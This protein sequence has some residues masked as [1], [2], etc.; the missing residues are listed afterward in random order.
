MTFVKPAA[1]TAAP[2]QEA[3]GRMEVF[4][5][6]TALFQTHIDRHVKG[7][8]LFRKAAGKAPPCLAEAEY[9][10]PSGLVS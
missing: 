4:H 2:G 3:V 5:L 7:A 8:Q 6:G 9:R 1:P 10:A